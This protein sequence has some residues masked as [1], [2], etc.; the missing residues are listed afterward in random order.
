MHSFG[1]VITTSSI[2]I[3]LEV[4]FGFLEQLSQQQFHLFPLHCDVVDKEA[5]GEGE[6]Q[7]NQPTVLAAG[8]AQEKLV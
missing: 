7:P 2:Q 3:C 6:E 4:R 1:T 8:K 5:K